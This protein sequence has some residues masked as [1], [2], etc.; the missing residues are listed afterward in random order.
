[1]FIVTV[2]IYKKNIYFTPKA[3]YHPKRRKIFIFE[4]KS[5]KK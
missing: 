2:K 5:N 1:M 4:Y 3:H